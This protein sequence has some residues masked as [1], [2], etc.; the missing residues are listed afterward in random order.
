MI[1]R[2]VRKPRSRGFGIQSPSIYRFVRYVLDERWPYYAYADLRDALPDLPK[3]ERSKAEML[4]RLSNASGGALWRLTAGVPEFYADYVTAGGRQAQTVR[5]TDGGWPESAGEQEIWM[6]D[7]ADAEPV[8][9]VLDRIT[10]QKPVC[11]VL[12]NIRE[13]AATRE[14]FRRFCVL[15]EVRT[16]FDMY[17]I[18]LFTFCPNWP[19]QTY[20]VNHGR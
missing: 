10:G 8:L 2:L 19:C 6:A 12:D 4:F 9:T 11:L 16:I 15:S 20:K 13:S 17:D 1:A 7:A 5:Q 3:R 14:M 18:A